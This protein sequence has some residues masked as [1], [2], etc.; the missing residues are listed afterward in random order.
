MG[1]GYVILQ[2]RDRRAEKSA[3]KPLQD[4]PLALLDPSIP[5][6][7]DDQV[8]IL[9]KKFTA[10][11]KPAATSSA[12]KAL[13]AENEAFMANLATEAMADR[14][15]NVQAGLLLTSREFCQRLQITRQAVSKA[16]KEFRLFS[17]DGPSGTLLYPAFFA[18]PAANRRDLERVSQALGDLPGPSKWQFF[19]TPKASLRGRTPIEALANGET[20]S[21]LVAAAGFRER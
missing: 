12:R 1:D 3:G 13:L 7:S 8:K 10:P 11:T 4:E 14:Q 6:I 5:T 16:I 9:L 20:D 2:V 19:T 18:N 15:K 21:V 17:L